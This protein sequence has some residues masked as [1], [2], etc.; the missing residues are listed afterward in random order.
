MTRP[1]ETIAVRVDATPE[2]A[3]RLSKTVKNN[4]E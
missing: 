1:T 3:A 2:L 4:G